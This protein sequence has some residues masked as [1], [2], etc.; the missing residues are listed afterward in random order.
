MTGVGHYLI[1]HI[2]PAAALCVLDHLLLPF[3]ICP[4]V[5]QYWWGTWHVLDAF[6]SYF[7]LE[8]IVTG[9]VLEFCNIFTTTCDEQYCMFYL[10][11]YT[12]FLN[13]SAKKYYVKYVFVFY[14]CYF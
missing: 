7:N 11:I 4:L 1:R 2:S 14:L 5:L 12:H 13:I 8:L 9:V 10:V 3:L 6:F